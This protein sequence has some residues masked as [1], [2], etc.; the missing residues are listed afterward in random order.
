ML[1]TPLLLTL[2]SFLNIIYIYIFTIDDK[3]NKLI[4]KYKVTVEIS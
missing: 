2:Y 4:I 3:S 1:P